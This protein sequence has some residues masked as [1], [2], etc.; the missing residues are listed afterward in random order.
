MEIGRRKVT[1]RVSRKKTSADADSVA[2]AES[3]AT[4]HSSPD[5]SPPEAE[6]TLEMNDN[7]INRNTNDENAATTDGGI[8]LPTAVRET[9]KAD[10]ESTSLE[11]SAT[12]NHTTDGNDATP[13]MSQHDTAPSGGSDSS[14]L[15]IPMDQPEAAASEDN[16]TVD[17]SQQDGDARLFDSDSPAGDDPESAISEPDDLQSEFPSEAG[18]AEGLAPS[19]ETDL[20]SG[21]EMSAVDSSEPDRTSPAGPPPSSPLG[22]ARWDSRWT[23]AWSAP[24]VAPTVAR[25][26]LS[27]PADANRAG[28]AASISESAAAA[29][30]ISPIAEDTSISASIISK[31]PDNIPALLRLPESTLADEPLARVLAGD[32][33]HSNF[34]ASS[35]IAK[36]VQ[37]GNGNSSESESPVLRFQFRAKAA[38]ALT[39]E[40]AAEQ[41]SDLPGNSNR[42]GRIGRRNELG[43]GG[44]G[45]QTT[46][47]DRSGRTTDLGSE[48][49]ASEILSIPGERIPS[50]EW[51]DAASGM[52]LDASLTVGEVSLSPETAAE[53]DAPDERAGRTK[54]RKDRNRGRRRDRNGSDLAADDAADIEDALEDRLVGDIDGLAAENDTSDVLLGNG[55]PPM[56]DEEL[57]AEAEALSRIGLDQRLGKEILVNTGSRETRIAYVVGG[58]LTELHIEREERLVGA[59]CKARVDR[60][61]P[62]IDAA[63]VDISLDRNAF[64]MAGDVVPEE[65]E[66]EPSSG[67]RSH[68]H[69]SISD[70][71]KP[72]QE[73][74]VQI[75][76]APRGTKGARVAT[77]VS[78]PGRFLVLMPDS[79]TV[80][81]SR[82]IDDDHER[83]RLKKIARSIRPPGFG[84]IVRTEAEN[85]TDEELRND[86]LFLMRLW[87]QIQQKYKVARAPSIV[88]R[89]LSLTFKII[90][91]LFSSD[92]NRFVID[93]REEWEKVIELV[94]FI[95]PKLRSR[96]I[97]YEDPVPLFERV[98]IEDEI[99]RLFRH[100]I[101]L[102][103]GGYLI[104]DETEALTTIDVNS[105]KFVGTTNPSQTIF[106]NNME[107]VVEIC[108]QLRLRDI[109]GMIIL[110]F[111]DMSS[112]KDRAAVMKALDANLRKDR[113]RTKIAHLS[114]LGLVEMTRKRTGETFSE[115]TTE[116]CSYCSG[117]GRTLNPDTVSILVER[118]IRKQGLDVNDEA[119]LV[120]VNPAV[121]PYLI[122]PDASNVE[123]LEREMRRGVYVRATDNL[124]IEKYEVVPADI[125]EMERQLVPYREGQV[126]D[127]VVEQTPAIN[128]PHAIARLDGYLVDLVNGG[129]YLGRRVRAKLTRVGRSV[130]V[131]EVVGGGRPV[132]KLGGI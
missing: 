97:L 50:E 127:C 99:E 102:K 78:L 39:P 46:A 11:A 121:A 9:E 115:L 85:K 21:S 73:I 108:R 116:L 18:T 29:A 86:V 12:L 8:E 98:G 45:R 96:V 124:H 77:R 15:D 44:P 58:M 23:A 47:P 131:G 28:S 68:R 31:D 91:D 82:K 74:M 75:S 65:D 119:F 132:D 3:A 61:L 32:L 94:E 16:L 38:G 76:K 59:V 83:D 34:T 125:Q 19:A 95:S 54:R 33:S 81:V 129:Q 25:T 40:Q 87:E 128:L 118:E 100:K 84:V 36:D 113:S 105:G 43:R 48:F 57:L 5:G 130:A 79:E 17:N 22:G 103:S 122:G 26:G 20:T 66:D 67:R 4:T 6:I 60:I 42:T 35:P 1:R 24:A 64:L 80:G 62:G 89:D 30:A 110:D 111:I 92:V 69:L 117:R 51:L 56:Q 10:S 49:D 41:Q 72:R 120:M 37:P 93:S 71:V 52:E 114:P 106:K 70:L 14:L 107:A 53:S 123:R 88:H 104:I 126:V 109:G 2:S 55:M 63:F 7:E 13:E 101:W 112:A 27:T 90:R